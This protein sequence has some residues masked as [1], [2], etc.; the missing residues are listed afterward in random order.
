M[1]CPRCGTQNQED[2]KFCRE[3]GSALRGE[4][5][6]GLTFGEKVERVREELAG[7]DCGRCGYER[8]EENAEAIVQGESAYDS[9]MQASPEAQERIRE[10]VGAS[11]RISVATQIWRSLTSVKLALALIGVLA[12][13]SIVGTVIPQGQP[14]ANYLNR[15]G[16]TG[17][18]LIEFFLVDRIFHSWYYLGLLML[19]AVNT[20]ACLSKRFRVSWRMLSK[21]Q[22]GQSASGMEKLENSAEIS[23]SRG[24]IE[25]LERVQHTL[26]SRGYR[27]SRKGAQ[28]KGSKHL[29]GRLGV[30]LFHASLI[31]LLLGALVGG[32]AG[33]ESFQVLHRGETVQVPGRDF[34]LRVEDLWTENYPDSSRIK[35][36][37]TKLTI[38]DDGGREVMTR[39]I[40]VNHPLTYRGVSFYQSSFG[41]DWSRGAQLSFQV[42]EAGS[43]A[44]L[45]EYEDVKIQGTFPIVPEEGLEAELA[46]F[47]PDFIMTNQGPANRSQRL[48]NPAAFLEVYRD[49]QLQYRGWTF[50]QFPDMQIW[51]PAG[52][53]S[54]QEGADPDEQAT[55][56][57]SAAMPYR[58]DIIGM[59]A[60]EFTGL[61]I[62]YNPGL[63]VIYSSFALMVLGLF[64]N[65]YLPPRRMWA[66]AERGR[67]YLGGVGRDNREFAD[68]FE[69]LL[70]RVRLD[71]S[72]PLDAPAPGSRV[73][74]DESELAEG[75]A[76]PSGGEGS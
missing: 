42:R 17:Y 26:R 68:E 57:G 35:D 51:V 59:H 29:Y 60:P 41:T 64:L 76:Y 19:L 66:I 71:I 69:G 5:A 74:G 55:G 32:F 6:R 48:R 34:Q 37:Y 56:H 14:S 20:L 75:R 63:W 18:K 62:S 27:V 25:A 52:P 44:V 23:I 53:A 54:G 72:K 9:C 47:Y 50:A 39:T 2:S 31:L 22:G 1:Q 24:P 46:A 67:L 43:D 58:I 4:V 30:D 45:G 65:F 40:E 28:L 12:L 49:D 16:S 73:S 3:C 10:I 15:Y 33:F 70:E 38:I 36:W 13:L 11:E 7:L 21:P 8:C 61:Q